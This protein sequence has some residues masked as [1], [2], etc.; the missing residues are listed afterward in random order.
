EFDRSASAATAGDIGEEGER[1]LRRALEALEIDV[2]DAEPPAIAL[3]PFEIV[4]KRPDEVAA[5]LD[6]IGERAARGGKMIA[7]IGDTVV[8]VHGA[9]RRDRIVVAG[10]VLGHVDFRIAVTVAQAMER[11]G[12]AARVD[13][14]T[15][16]GKARPGWHR[17]EPRPE[18]VLRRSG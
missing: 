12:E 18:Q 7:Q 11:V 17:A 6:A 4:Q 2:D 8:V 5:Q 15:E 14:P 10:T 13:R 9:I 3:G 16:G 1:R